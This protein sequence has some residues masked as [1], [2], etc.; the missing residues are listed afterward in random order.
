VPASWRSAA[1]IFQVV[2]FGYEDV[3]NAVSARC[4]EGRQ[5][6]AE[7]AQTLHSV[8]GRYDAEEAKNDHMIRD[9]Y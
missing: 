7:I 2:V 8:A 4:R 1:G 5:R 9:L 3:V 6:M